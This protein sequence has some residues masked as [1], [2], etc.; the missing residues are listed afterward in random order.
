MKVESQEVKVV[1]KDGDDVHHRLPATTTPSTLIQRARD[2]QRARSPSRA[3]PAPRG[4][5][6]DLARSLRPVHRVLDLPDEPHA[7][8]R[9]QGDELRQEPG[10]ADGRRRPED[11]L[12]GRGRRRRGRRGAARDQGV[13]REPQEVPGPRRPHPQGR[14]AV[15]PPG[16]RQDPARPRGR[17]RGRR[18]LLLDLGIRLRRDVRRRRRL[19]GARPVRAGQAVEP[20]HH[21]HGRDRRRRPPPRGGPRAVA[22]TSASRPSTSCWSRWTASRPRTTSS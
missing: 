6:P 1:T 5:R 12:Q 17:R 11:H 20:L 8:R 16:N 14:P 4:G 18:A 7:G 19:P 13:P 15:R 9:L 21:L 3:S 2:R 10:Q 22:T